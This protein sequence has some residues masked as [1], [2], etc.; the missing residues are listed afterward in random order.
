MSDESSKHFTPFTRK[1]LFRP[2]ENNLKTGLK[3]I[4]TSILDLRMPTVFHIGTDIVD[5]ESKVRI[6]VPVQYFKVLAYLATGTVS[7]GADLTS[8]LVTVSR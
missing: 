6:E 5:Y 2:S 3:H 1:S 4:R 8:P 7:T